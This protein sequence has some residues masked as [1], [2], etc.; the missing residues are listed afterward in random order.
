MKTEKDFREFTDTKEVIQKGDYWTPKTEENWQ[1]VKSVVF[2]GLR[3]FAKSDYRFK[4]KRPKEKEP[5]VGMSAFTISH[6]AKKQKYAPTGTQ[7]ETSS[8]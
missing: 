1:E 4:T 5:E 2:A 6:T 3:A 8:K 7:K